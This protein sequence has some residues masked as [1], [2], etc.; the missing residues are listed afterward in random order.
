MGEPLP[1]SSFA[2]SSALT[3]LS[4]SNISNRSFEGCRGTAREKP[5]VCSP[6]LNDTLRRHPVFKKAEGKPMHFRSPYIKSDI[7]RCAGVCTLAF[8][9]I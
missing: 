8:I 1:G 4:I 7:I 3:P 5:V 2:S 6:P 9:W